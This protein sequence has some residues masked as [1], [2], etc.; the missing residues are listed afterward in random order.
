MTNFLTITERVN[1]L[2]KPNVFVTKPLLPEAL[3]LLKSQCNVE[4]NREHR[5]LPKQELLEKIQGRDAI[6]VVG[7]PIDEEIF[8][9]AKPYCKIFAA[10]GVGY[11]NIDVAGATKQGVWVSNT[12]DVV[13]GPTAD[14]AWTLL[15]STARRVVEC[16][17]F[18]RSGKKGWGPTNMIGT[19]VSGKTLGIV[20][21][22]HIGTAVAK[23]GKGFDMNILY[24][25]LKP[26]PTFEALSG[27]KFVSKEQ[28]LQEADFI[29][30]H[31][32]LLPSTRHFISTGE[33]HLMKKNAIL[34]NTSRGPVVHEQA[35]LEALRS[36][37]I[38]GAGLDV[39]EHEPQLE[40][41]LSDLDNVILTPHIGTATL[42][43]RIAMGEVCAKNIFAA[44]KGEL[45]PNCL[46]PEAIKNR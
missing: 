26:N 5:T 3:E 14:H 10:H 17:R 6:L 45:P 24:T 28:L 21:G 38:K 16:D 39:F 1:I 46:N 34:V 7:T 13:T 36:G 33:L 15:L 18:V 11:D 37:L 12:P 41:G 42:D 4:M 31:I 25:D 40:P 9:T 2:N 8:Q 20:G 19:Q 32:P 35:L 30:I 43:T 23:R 27:G 44:L 29:S 22:G